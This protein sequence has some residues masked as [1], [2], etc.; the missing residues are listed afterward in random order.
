MR[1]GCRRPP[2]GDEAPQGLS[3]VHYYGLPNVFPTNRLETRAQSL[4]RSPARD[5]GGGQGSHR[6]F[7][8]ESGSSRACLRSPVDPK[9]V[10]GS[11]GDGLRSAAKGLTSA[12]RVVAS[13]YREQHGES[14]VDPEDLILTTSTSEGYSYVFR[15]MCNPDD[16][17]LVPKPSYPLFEFLADLQDVTLKS[18]TLLYDHGWHID[19]P[20]FAEALVP[21]LGRSWWC[22]PTIRQV[23]TPAQRTCAVEFVLPRARSCSHRRRS[24]S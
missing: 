5:P 7:D 4:Y 24:I 21:A 10:I 23:P 22:I 9:I 11:G 17:V 2:V 6:P 18:Y 13:Y 16:E 15:L 19:F 12:R 8:F 1:K 20:S 14:A 3:R